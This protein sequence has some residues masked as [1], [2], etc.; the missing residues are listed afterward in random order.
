MDG[1][2]VRRE[3]SHAPVTAMHIN[4]T[5][6]NAGERLRRTA[7]LRWRLGLLYTDWPKRYVDKLFP[8][9]G[10]MRGTNVKKVWERN[11]KAKAKR[12]YLMKLLYKKIA[13]QLEEWR[14]GFE[15]CDMETGEIYW[16]KL[17]V[18]SCVFDL[19]AMAE[20]TGLVRS[21]KE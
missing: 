1:V 14:D 6:Y 13:D 4:A 19:P 3:L 12:T 9:L 11:R 8:K 5:P 20:A 15:F 2:Q 21:K 16:V 17:Y 10:I 7:A 18:L